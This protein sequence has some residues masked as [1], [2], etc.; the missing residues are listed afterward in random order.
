MAPSVT[1]PVLFPLEAGKPSVEFRFNVITAQ[2]LE[3]R[4]GCAP[5]MLS[6]RGQSVKA[7]VLMLTYALQHA[8]PDINENKAARLIQRY[9]ENGGKVK[10]LAEALTEAMNASGVYGER[11][12]SATEDEGDADPL[13]KTSQETLDG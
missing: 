7:L 5:W 6:M 13:A 8:R 10:A 11:E 2:A 3:E 9:L 12:E 1:A 4:A